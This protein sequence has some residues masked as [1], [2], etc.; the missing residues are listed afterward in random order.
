MKKTFYIFLVSVL[1]LSSCSK[2]DDYENDSANV[3]LRKEIGKENNKVTYSSEYV[4]NGNR[5]V[6]IGDV[7]FT[8]T[9]NYIT[10][11]A[12]AYI[13]YEFGYDNGKLVSYTEKFTGDI[14]FYKTVYIHNVDGTVSFKEYYVFNSMETE[15]SR[16]NLQ[17]VDGNLVK[18]EY[19]MKDNNEVVTQTIIKEYDTKNNPY[20]N[21]LG[22]DLLFDD[23]RFLS[24]LNGNKNNLVKTTSTASNIKEFFSDSLQKSISIFE[25]SYNS[26][27][28]PT[29]RTSID[30][31]EI[32]TKEY[33]Y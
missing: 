23:D 24:I 25:Y 32:S 9:G 15:R 27:G 26:K 19:V 6:S 21:I 33:F 18:K 3:L 12:S 13:T 11:Q 7:S 31:N 16:G 8:Y 30:N 10:K 20:K 1:I 17:F 4:Y 5:I 28:F 29:L 22:C 2:D 14:S